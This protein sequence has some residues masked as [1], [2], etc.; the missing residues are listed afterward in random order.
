[1]KKNKK[2]PSLPLDEAPITTPFVLA[3]DGGKTCGVATYRVPSNQIVSLKSYSPEQ[4]LF[5]LVKTFK[6][7]VYTLII[8][9]TDNNIP[10]FAQRQIGNERVGKRIAEFVGRNKQTT[11]LLIKVAELAGF[12]VILMKPTT[13]KWTSEKV[14]KEFG[15]LFSVTNEHTRDAIRML[16]IYFNL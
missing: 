15:H 9:D 5:T 1:M 11:R 6:P 3:I 14:E 16:A 12:R 4:L 10:V 2:Q 7:E 13:K 8:E